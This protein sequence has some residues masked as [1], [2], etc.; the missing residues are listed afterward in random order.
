MQIRLR[1]HLT[2]RW[3]SCVIQVCLRTDGHRSST[4]GR[5]CLDIEILCHPVVGPGVLRRT[6]MAYHVSRSIHLV[7]R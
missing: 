4:W 2:P 7:E 1:T 6:G 3:A 5:D